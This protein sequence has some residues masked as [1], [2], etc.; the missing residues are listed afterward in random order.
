MVQ[1]T[2]A[3][4]PSS[5]S[6]WSNHHRHIRIPYSA[7]PYTNEC[8]YLPLTKDGKGA[9]LVPISDGQVQGPERFASL[10]EVK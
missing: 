8:R 2:E 1:R 7:K 10:L 5:E 9:M 6:Y 3:A 4:C